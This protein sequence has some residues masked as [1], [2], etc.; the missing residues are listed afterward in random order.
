MSRNNQ[1]STVLVAD[2]N[3]AVLAEGNSPDALA[4]GQLGVFDANTGLSVDATSDSPREFF[5]AVGLDRDGDATQD[6]IKVSA[7]QYIQR[8]GV[9]TYN[10]REHSAAQ[11]M[12]V[13][14]ADYLAEC[15]TTYALKVEF[16]NQEI[17]RTQGFNQFTKTY[18]IKTDCC[19]SCETCY[20]A[21]ANEVTLKMVAE[22]NLDES[23][24]LTAKAV[25]RQAVTTATHGTSADLA[26]GD[27]ISD[28]DIAALIAFNALDTTADEDKVY[29]DIVLTTNNLA[30]RNFCGVNLK[31]FHPRG[32]VIIASLVDGFN[33]N[34]AV[35][36]LQEIAF[37]EGNG[38][39]VQQKEFHAA[40]NAQNQP[41]VLSE[42][43]GMHIEFDTFA[44]KS[45]KYDQFNLEW[46]FTS[47]QEGTPYVAQLNTIIAVPNGNT[48][49]RNS[50]AALLDKILTGTVANGFD[51]K[52]D[53]VAA[54]NTGDTVVSPTSAIDDKEL[55]G[56]D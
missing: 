43:T 26:E 53:D 55:D 42:A 41:Y 1:I 23:G 48:T 6:D 34:A 39:D 5:I 19:D 24:L 49:A 12:I 44:D 46:D 15:E 32:T 56:I 13:E 8:S 3:V 22:V 54:A 4:V 7:G 33:C 52:A 2:N 17:Y 28:A 36:T 27:D 51:A 14:V 18:A 20:S 37:E 21:D 9:V 11:P 50:I 30:V 38:Y 25:T 10:F 29:T 40:G 45:E 47:Q 16:R 31:Y 35:N